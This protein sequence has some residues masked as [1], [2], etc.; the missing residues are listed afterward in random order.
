MPE[1]EREK[2]LSRKKVFFYLDPSRVDRELLREE[3]MRC[4]A[5]GYSQDIGNITP[6]ANVVS[7]PLFANHEKLIGCLILIGTFPEKRIQEYGPKVAGIAR[8]I[9]QKLG[10][11][12]ETIYPKQSRNA[13]K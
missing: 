6:G 12:V 9:S 8:Q 13:G 1:T 7:A 10:A 5:L 11:N 3:L 2:I 4:R